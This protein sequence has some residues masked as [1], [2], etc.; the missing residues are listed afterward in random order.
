MSQNA[1]DINCDLGEGTGNETGIMPFISSVN[2]ACGFHAGNALTMQETVRLAKKHAVCIGAHPSFND[3]EHFGRR[4]MHLP[5]TEIYAI[6]LY[7]VG[8]LSAIC[9]AEKTRIH[10]IKLHGALYNQ[11]STDK[12]VAEAAVAAIKDLDASLVIYGLSGSVLISL[13]KAAGLKTAAEVFAD[14]T[15]TPEG[16]LTSRSMPHALIT[17]VAEVTQQVLGFVFNQSVIATDQSLVKIT[18]ETICIHGDGLHAPVF[19]K[20]V[21]HALAEKNIKIQSPA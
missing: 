21:N 11:A 19:A 14:R 18:A 5:A 7:Q 6:I 16:L 8:A 10:H 17:D 3:P 20:A 4:T 12:L 9:Q 1:I 2:I 15:Y 13:A